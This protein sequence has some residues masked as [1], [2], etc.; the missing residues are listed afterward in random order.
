MQAF[1]VE[2]LLTTIAEWLDEAVLV[3]NS[4]DGA[5]IKLADDALVAARTGGGS[6]EN[7]VAVAQYSCT[8]RGQV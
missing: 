2:Q 4:S 5:I 8:E 7:T 3:C 1:N 6:R